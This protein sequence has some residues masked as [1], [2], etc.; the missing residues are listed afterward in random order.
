MILTLAELNKL[1]AAIKTV[2]PNSYGYT[3][4]PNAKH[5][6]Y[7]L[8]RTRDESFELENAI[9]RVRYGIK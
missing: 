4:D 3:V 5:P 2:Y 7:V 6:E 9:L 8:F 1:V